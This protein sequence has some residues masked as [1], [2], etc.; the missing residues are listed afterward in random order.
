MFLVSFTEL[1]QEKG[2]HKITQSFSLECLRV[3]IPISTKREFKIPQSWGE[4][5]MKKKKFAGF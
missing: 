2:E 4:V 3:N 1:G 5:K